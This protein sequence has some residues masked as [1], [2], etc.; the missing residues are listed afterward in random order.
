MY[1]IG[2][3]DIWSC[4]EEFDTKDDAI[5]A[6]RKEAIAE[7]T[8]NSNYGSKFQ[9]KSFQVSRVEGVIPCGVDID[10]ILENISENVYDDVGEAAE[11]YLDDV[12]KEHRDELEEKLNDVL[13]DWIK[14][15]NYEPTCF[16]IVAIET[17][18]I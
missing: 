11:G 1:Q 7:N 2:Q 3:S 17:I 8:I 5:I 14:R 18:Q 15:H 9:H 16:K 10:D 4:S 6:G 13:F 12:T